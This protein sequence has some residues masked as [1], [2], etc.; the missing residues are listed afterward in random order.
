M[1]HLL[2]LFLQNEGEVILE[3][4]TAVMCTVLRRLGRLVQQNWNEW[5]KRVALPTVEPEPVSVELEEGDEP[6]IKDRVDE[7]KELVELIN[8]MVGEPFRYKL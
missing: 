1:S 8:K 2:F 7:I 5:F 6:Q 3:Y 4:L